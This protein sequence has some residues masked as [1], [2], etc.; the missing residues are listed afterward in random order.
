[1]KKNYLKILT[2]LVCVTGCGVGLSACNSTS[3][4]VSNVSSINSSTP[5]SESSVSTSVSSEIENI[6]VESITL[7]KSSLTLEVGEE[8]T[9]IATIMPNDATNK[10]VTWNVE[11]AGVITVDNGKITAIASGNAVV[12]ASA[13]E[14]RAT[15]NVT[16]NKK[17]TTTI[18][19]TYYMITVSPTGWAVDANH[20]FI[21]NKDGTGD[22]DGAGTYTIDNGVI[23]ITNNVSQSVCYAK[24]DG[25]I[26]WLFASK[27][28]VN[29]ISK[30]SQALYSLSEITQ[31]DRERIESIF[32]DGVFNPN[33]KDPVDENGVFHLEK[34]EVGGNLLGGQP[35][36]GYDPKYVVDKTDDTLKIDYEGVYGNSYHV[37]ELQ[38]IGSYLQEKNV[39]TAKVTNNGDETVN[40]RVNITANKVGNNDSCNISATMDGEVVRTD[41][42]WGG[43]FFY[44]EAGKTANIE[45]IYDNSRTLYAVQFMSDS[46]TNLAQAYNGS[47][48]ICDM[49]IA[50][51][52]TSSDDVFVDES[53][54][55]LDFSKPGYQGFY[56]ANGYSN[57][58]MFNCYWSNTCAQ[59]NDSTLNMTVKKDTNNNNPTGY[60]GAEYRTDN[61]YSYGYYEVC[62]KPAKGSGLVSSFFT[63]T[64]N[65]RWDEIDIEFLGKD[66]TKVQFNY[67]IDGVGG[68]EKLYDLGFDASSEFHVYAFDWKSNSITWYVDGKAVYTATESIPEYP[69]QIMMNIWNCTG[70]DEWTGP[71]DESALPATASYKWVAYVP[72]AN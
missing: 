17:E 51:E 13:G 39:F 59:I 57:G 48:E 19:A 28:D 5:S 45:I 64:N 66:T 21:F 60:L 4:S 70:I 68:H 72:Y 24:I 15:C 6:E 49:K 16:V 3:S 27:E 22:F 61:V 67:Y 65:P 43:S 23:T 63:Y 2:T 42:E 47:I 1:M 29:D 50:S 20:A 44:I 10:T 41:S 56:A 32:G 69:Q 33:I 55:I 18:N 31:E 52:N 53:Y 11:P 7:N 35:A 37:V 38:G 25:N 26:L 34:I 36:N 62:M 40:L 46:S 71:L 12:I 9:L 30:S 8:E 14:K 58:G 54:R